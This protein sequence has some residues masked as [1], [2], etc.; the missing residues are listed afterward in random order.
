MPREPAARLWH[1]AT[2]LREHRGDGHNAVLVAHGVGGTEAHV[3]T[4]LAFGMPAAEFSRLHHLPPAR[5]EAAVDGLRVRGLVDADGGFT[6]AGRDLRERIEQLTD[7]A[8]APAYDVL[9]DAELDEL[10]AGLTPIA[11][12]AGS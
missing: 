8:A 6:P 2:L 11:D 7:V 9:E 4:A 10:V 3:L 5:V 1:A 12:A